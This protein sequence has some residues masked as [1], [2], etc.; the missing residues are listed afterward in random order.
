MKEEKKIC[1][2]NGKH[3]K[4]KEI[5]KNTASKKYYQK[6]RY[7]KMTNRLISLRDV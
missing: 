7:F 4:Y 2:K 5:S 6:Q 1:H 3:K